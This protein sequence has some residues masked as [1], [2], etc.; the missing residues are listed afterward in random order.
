MSYITTGNDVHVLGSLSLLATLLQAKELD[1]SM[2]D[3]LGILPQ[4]KQHKKHLLQ[5]L[6][7]EGLG[8]EQLFSSENSLAKDSIN[9]E[10]DGYIQKLKDHYGQSYFEESGASYQKHRY[11]VRW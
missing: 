11:Q 3:G 6:V 5:A 8:E 7:G 4:R 9:T 1:E 10:L 2:L